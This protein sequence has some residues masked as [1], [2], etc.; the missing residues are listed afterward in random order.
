M[1]VIMHC[2]TEYVGLKPLVED[3]NVLLVCNALKQV[4]SDWLDRNA[5][6]FVNLGLLF[7]RIADRSKLQPL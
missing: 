7:A 3:A 1:R 6:G 5:Y 4:A 2:V